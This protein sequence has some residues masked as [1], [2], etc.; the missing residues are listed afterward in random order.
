MMTILIIVVHAMGINKINMI[1]K[2]KLTGVVLTQEG[3]FQLVFEY[4]PDTPYT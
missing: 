4:F 3:G 1:K 2:K